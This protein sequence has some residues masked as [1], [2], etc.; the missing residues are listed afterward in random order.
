M[1]QLADAAGSKGVQSLVAEAGRDLAQRGEKGEQNDHRN[2]EGDHG[3][4]GGEGEPD[5]WFV[6]LGHGQNTPARKRTT[7][8]STAH[9]T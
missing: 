9:A 5:D 3:A 7:T 2:A 4:A 8:D 6:R 1:N